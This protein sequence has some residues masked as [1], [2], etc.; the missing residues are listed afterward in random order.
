[1][2]ID[3]P[4]FIS[5]DAKETQ[6]SSGESARSPQDLGAETI[7]LKTLLVLQ[8]IKY[9]AKNLVDGEKTRC[10]SFSKRHR[11]LCYRA[12]GLVCAGMRETCKSAPCQDGTG[13]DQAVMVWV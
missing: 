6:Y 11:Y 1:M 4:R 10:S 9:A 13:L 5:Q 7:V 12:C 3:R 8:M 2:H